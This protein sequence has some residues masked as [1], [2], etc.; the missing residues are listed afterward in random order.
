MKNPFT[1]GIIQDAENFCNRTKELA[2]LTKFARSGTDVV[3]SS[4]RRFGKSSLAK[5]VQ[6]DIE[7][8]G[9]LTAY[10]DL[11]PIS[12]EHDVTTRLASSIIQGIGK[13]AD[14]Q[15]FTDKMKG[16]FKRFRPSFEIKPNGYSISVGFDRSTTTDVLLDDIMEGLQ[17]YV[18]KH[19][20]SACIVL[21]E[22]Q[23]ITELPGAKKIEGTL[24]SHIQ[25]HK[26]I[27]YFFVGSRRRIL[28]DMFN[29]KKRPFYKSA[30][31]YPLGTISEEEMTPFIVKHFAHTEKR[32]SNTV[33]QHIYQ[34]V[35]GYPYYVQ[36]LALVAW[37]A[38]EADCTL[39]I[40]DQSYEFLITSESADFEGIWNGLPLGQ[41]ATLKAF[42]QE[43]TNTPFSRGY[44]EQFEL[45][46]GG[47]QKSIQA[48]M[49]RDLIEKSKEGTH[50][51]TDPVFCEWI[52][53][54]G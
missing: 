25:T 1:I 26:N 38:S 2:E 35:R 36:K 15:T 24:R 44:L 10:V 46:V 7:K 17:T 6:A 45:S 20:L 18:T 29:D 30:I 19:K 50:R 32:C 11:F 28:S 40:V 54:A 42:A 13:G 23:E 9:I 51:L 52:K 8:E 48:L 31:F 39:D 22:F 14:P 5:R 4:P 53:R 41:K 12:S 33:A 21:D 3:L 16:L 34:L 43:P 47:F 27:S 37:N 49:K